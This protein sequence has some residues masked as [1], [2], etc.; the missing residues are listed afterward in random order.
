MILWRFMTS[1]LWKCD[2]VLEDRYCPKMI[3]IPSQE[4]KGRRMKRSSDQMAAVAL[5][6]EQVTVKPDFARERNEHDEQ[7]LEKNTENVAETISH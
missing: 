4:K 3:Q 2:T 7:A 1:S 6:R 5:K